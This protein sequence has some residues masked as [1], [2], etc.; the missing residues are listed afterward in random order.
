[1]AE[2]TLLSPTTTATGPAETRGLDPVVPAVAQL[3]ADPMRKMYSAVNMYNE[4][5]TREF[6]TSREP[7]AAGAVLDKNTREMQHMARDMGATSEE[8]GT[9]L[10]EAKSTQGKNLKPEERDAMR[11]EATAAL[12]EKYGDDAGRVFRLAT[13]LARR[14]PR[15]VKFL[16]SSGAGDSPRVALTLAEMALRAR[17]RGELKD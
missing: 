15:M 11:R 16:N 7:L 9:L 5:A 12:R 14:D 2:P 6:F 13:T 4:A 8:Y 1:M 10:S 3:R 17:T